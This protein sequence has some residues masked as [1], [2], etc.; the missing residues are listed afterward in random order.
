MNNSLYHACDLFLNYFQILKEISVAYPPPGKNAAN[1]YFREVSLT[2]ERVIVLGKDYSYNIPL[3]SDGYGI[4]EAFKIFYNH[5]QAGFREC[6]NYKA[7]WATHMVV[8][9]PVFKDVV[10]GMIIP[11]IITF[12]SAFVDPDAFTNNLK[13]YGKILYD[14][15][16]NTGLVTHGT[17][18]NGWISVY[19]RDAANGAINHLN[20]KYS[21]TGIVGYKA[22]RIIIG[23]LETISKLD[24]EHHKPWLSASWQ[25]NFQI[26]CEGATL[27]LAGAK[28]EYQ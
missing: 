28:K 25:A 16:K 1:G 9:W 21:Q 12:A 14:K 26:I 13:N 27:A 10:V 8:F 18:A 23:I 7:S 15:I 5:T 17:H 24:T 4:Y 19:F 22:A 20:S 3:N 6:K 11:T 2:H